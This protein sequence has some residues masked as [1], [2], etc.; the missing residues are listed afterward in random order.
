LANSSATLAEDQAEK[1]Q[2]E[3]SR[4]DL[5]ASARRVQEERD[6]TRAQVQ[7]AQA[8]IHAQQERALELAKPDLPVRVAL[9]RALLGAG[10]VLTVQNVSSSDL[11]ITADL[12]R[13]DAP[14]QTRELVIPH[15]GIREMGE[16]QGWAFLVGDSVALRNPRFRDW[17]NPPLPMPSRLRLAEPRL[18]S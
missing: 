5:E 2:V 14:S 9:R 17:R 15:N 1:A 7:F 11:P 8:E 18:V 16:Q 12:G 3:A 10:Q 13:A 4:S 6:A